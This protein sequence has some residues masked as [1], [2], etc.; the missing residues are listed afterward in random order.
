[1]RGV[2]RKCPICGAEIRAGRLMCIEHWGMVPRDLQKAVNRTWR[3]YKN[4]NHGH[5]AIEALGIYQRAYDAACQAVF[6]LVIKSPLPPRK[7][8]DF[9]R[10]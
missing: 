6:E 1:M 8:K 9:R 3:A 2:I 4:A 7:M 5:P 10:G